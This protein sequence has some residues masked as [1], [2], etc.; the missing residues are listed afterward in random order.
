MV[1][2]VKGGSGHK[3]Q[4]R[5]YTTDMSKSNKLRTINEEGE[6][7][8][9]VTKLLGN[10][11][12][13]VI[14]IDQIE[15]LCIIRGKFRGRGKR[16][17]TIQNGT[18]ILVG[19]RDF[20]SVKKDEK[21]K[22]DLLEVYSESDKIKLKSTNLD[23]NWTIFIDNDSKNTNTEKIEDDL[24]IFSNSNEEEYRKIM[25][26]QISTTRLDINIGSS[27]TNENN[28]IDIDDI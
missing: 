17:N 3:S 7:Y 1:K 28:E 20:E 18:W 16:D 8:A 14:C 5:K 6:I 10:G 27:N 2:N 19:I 11:M 21:G 15:R 22:C 4:A 23:I 25:E 13:H 24:F 9:Q 26:S 12:C